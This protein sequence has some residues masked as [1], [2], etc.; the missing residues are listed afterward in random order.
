MLCRGNSSSHSTRCLLIYNQ[1]KL[2][3]TSDID[4]CHVCK[5]FALHAAKN[6][7]HVFIISSFL[8][9]TGEIAVV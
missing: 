4:I 5:A 6:A 8:Y 7:Q 9:I 2:T 3:S 1:I